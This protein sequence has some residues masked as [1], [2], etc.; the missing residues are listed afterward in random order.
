MPPE[1]SRTDARGEG[2]HPKSTTELSQQLKRDGF[3]PS[4]FMRARHPE[5]FSDSSVTSLPTLTREVFQYH[6]EL[7]TSRKEETVFEHFCRR[8][9]EKELCPNL[10]PQTGPTGGG[11]SKCDAETYPVAEQIALRWYEGRASVATQERWAFAFSA[12]QEWSSKVR[13]DVKGI[14]DTR[15]G[16]DLI[17]FIT[18][19]FARDKTK[20][21]LEDEL[22]RAHGMKVRILDRNWILKCVF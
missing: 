2:T 3:R 20:A 19:R 18:S 5:L 21:A 10:S 9:A 15:R 14:A 6:L 16:Y 7:L 13:S 17:Y 1:P 4:D 12:K 22:T 8:L 11:D